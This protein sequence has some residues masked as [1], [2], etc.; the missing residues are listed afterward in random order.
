[1]PNLHRVG[2]ALWIAAALCVALAVSAAPAGAAVTIGQ[3]G[4]PTGTCGDGDPTV[5]ATSA[6]TPSYSVPAGGGVITS[7]SQLGSTIDPGQAKLIMWRPTSIATDFTVVAKSE[8][9]T[10]VSGM[11]LSF[12]T[13]IPVQAGDLLGIR[14]GTTPTDCFFVG[15]PGDSI[16]FRNDPGTDPEPADGSTQTLPSMLPNIRTNISAVVELDADGD[17]FGDETQDRC[18]TDASTQ[19]TCPPDTDPPET[20]ITKGAP[21]KTH[22]SKLKF[23]FVSDESDSTFQCKLKVKPFVGKRHTRPAK[24]KPA[25]FKAC[26]S[27]RKL[28]NLGAGKYKFKVIATD[29]AGNSDPSPAKDKFTVVD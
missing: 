22:K 23:K 26:E 19:G 20:T 18:P 9:Q 6:G 11:L 25:R 1:M 16:R 8:A 10:F 3:T 15:A 5:Q 21:N 4:V 27:P 2:P 12:P 24:F 7:W 28:K 17:G 14:A 13:R 29:A